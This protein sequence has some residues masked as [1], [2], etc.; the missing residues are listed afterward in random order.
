MDAVD[1]FFNV[2]IAYNI[3]KGCMTPIS[4]KSQKY[5]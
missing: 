4:C 1:D 5:M 3:N 2:I